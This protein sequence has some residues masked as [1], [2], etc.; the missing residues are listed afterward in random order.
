MNK[1]IKL[2]SFDLDGTLAE[3]KK[4]VS[5]N[6]AKLLETLLTKYHLC[7]I[8][9]GTLQQVLTQVIPKIN[10]KSQKYKKFFLLPVS[11]S[12][13]Y[14]FN[15]TTQKTAS[16]YSLKISKTDKTKIIKLLKTK[17]REMK[18]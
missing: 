16:I 2:L 18:L 4:P 12:Q 3:S 9:G 1:T 7:I 5:Y 6:M 14:Q 8:T 15:P 11:G 10:F 17:S 13:M